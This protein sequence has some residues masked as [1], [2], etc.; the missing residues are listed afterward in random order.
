MRKGRRPAEWPGM[1]EDKRSQKGGQKGHGAA[2]K[3]LE[4]HVSSGVLFQVG[5]EA[6]GGHRAEEGHVLTPVSK[7]H[8]GSYRDKG[9]N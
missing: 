4:G 6:L 8:S 5:W 7:N 3:C 1:R 2:W 9:R